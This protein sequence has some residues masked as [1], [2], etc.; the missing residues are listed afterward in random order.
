MFVYLLKSLKD[1]SRRYVGVTADLSKRLAEHNDG[2]SSHTAKYRP[3][4]VVVSIWFEDD[5]KALAFEKYLKAGSGHAF[6][7][8]H[9]W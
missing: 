7:N 2:K 5:N 1:P 4:Q 6:A 9:F 8:R 3:W